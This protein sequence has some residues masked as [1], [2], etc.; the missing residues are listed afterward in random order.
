MPTR[1][2]VP[3]RVA[4]SRR[5]VSLALGDRVNVALKVRQSEQSERVNIERR[6]DTAA[7]EDTFTLHNVS[8]VNRV[9]AEDVCN[10]VA[11]SKVM[12]AISISFANMGEIATAQPHRNDRGN[13]T[14]RTAQDRGN[15]TVRT[16]KDS[17]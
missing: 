6:A 10:A 1:G 15:C 17:G 12:V 16:A 9:K 14:V 3:V 13:R 8:G 2:T 11:C 4:S 7:A 5:D